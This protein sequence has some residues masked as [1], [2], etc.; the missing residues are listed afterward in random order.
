MAAAVKG[1]DR[2]P[3]AFTQ[4]LLNIV[5]RRLTPE[6]AVKFPRFRDKSHVRKDSTLEFDLPPYIP[7]D[8]TPLNKLGFDQLRNDLSS[9]GYTN[10]I[11]IP[12]EIEDSGFGVAQI[13][14]DESKYSANG[15]DSSIKY[16]VVSDLGRKP[17]LSIVGEQSKLAQEINLSVRPDIIHPRDLQMLKEPFQRYYIQ[18]SVEKNE[19]KMMS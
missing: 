14:L 13:F 19:V 12:D 18:F 8:G 3:Y 10:K 5:N 6:D 7:T 4:I 9:T 17:G 15:S 2:Q 16:T 11:D 1:G